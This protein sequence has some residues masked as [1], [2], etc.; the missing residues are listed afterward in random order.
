[1]IDSPLK[2]YYEKRQRNS[3]DPNVEFETVRERF[4]KWLAQWNDS[5]LIV[6]LENAIPPASSRA[7]GWIEFTDDVLQGRQGFYPVAQG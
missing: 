5:G 4:Y 6:I 3:D 7:D 1:V 2:T